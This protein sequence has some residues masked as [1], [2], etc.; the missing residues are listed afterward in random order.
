MITTIC[1]RSLRIIG[2]PFTTL[3]RFKH[4]Q[5]TCSYSKPTIETPEKDAKCVQS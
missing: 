2:F 1:A 4:F 3:R 5:L